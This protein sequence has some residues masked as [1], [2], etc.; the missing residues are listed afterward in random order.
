MDDLSIFDKRIYVMR[1]V[2]DRLGNLT[3]RKDRI[4]FSRIIGG[5]IV[6]FECE[7]GDEL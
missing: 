5:L 7:L 4:K 2:L 3:E 6:F 1:T